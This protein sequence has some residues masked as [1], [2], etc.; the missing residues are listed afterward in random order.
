MSWLLS[1]GL[2]AY[3][4]SS[5][6]SED[7]DVNDNSTKNDDGKEDGNVHQDSQQ[8]QEVETVNEP[9]T[10]ED[11]VIIDKTAR[12]V[13]RAG[14]ELEQKIRQRHA[15]DPKFAFLYQNNEYHNYYQSKIKYFQT[16][17]NV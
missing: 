8:D 13:A 16:N 7:D 15:R 10:E 11:R 17:P 5:S 6:D 2:G 14:P 9:K 1:S 4:D 12:F 3:G